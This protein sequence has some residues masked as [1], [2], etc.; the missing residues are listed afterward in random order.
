[1]PVLSRNFGKYRLVADLGHGG[2]ANVYLAAASGPAGVTKLLVVK[3]IKPEMA[4]D[5]AFVEMFLDEARLA[6]RVNHPNV[7]QTLEVGEEGGR[8]FLSMEFLDGQPLSRIQTRQGHER[9]TL[10][11]R[12]RVLADA[13]I[14]LHHAHEL[15]SYDGRPLGVVHR[16]ATPQ[17]IFVTY[18]GQVKVVDFGVAKAAT[19]SGQTST[20]VIKGKLSYMAPEQAR[21]E[22]IDRRADVFSVGVMFWE[23]VTGRRMWAGLSSEMGI[24]HRLAIGEVPRVPPDVAPEL[25]AIGD[26]ALAPEAA[27]RYPTAAAMAEDIE[28]YLERQRD[29]GSS[30]EIGARVGRMFATERAALHRVVNEQLAAIELA[31]TGANLA[32]PQIL[33]GETV[34]A[35]PPSFPDIVELSSLTAQPSASSLPPP[36]PAPAVP[37]PVVAG[38]G[39]NR[40]LVLLGVAVG[41]AS[42]FLLGAWRGWASRSATE[43][44]ASVTT[45]PSARVVSI[46]IAVHPPAARMFFDDEPLTGNPVTIMRPADGRTHLVRAEANEFLPRVRSLVVDKDY[47]LDFSLDRDPAAGSAVRPPVA[48]GAV[49]TAT[50][51]PVATTVAG[52][53]R[54]AGA[55]VV[56][57][58]N[59]AAAAPDAPV[60]KPAKGRRNV[61]ADNPYGP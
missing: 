35:L 48:G 25:R 42:I 51:S 5:P 33:D 4:S 52:P 55:T 59:N 14:G 18:D 16:D 30:R 45:A 36:P 58:A 32:L 13:L 43:P 3:E 2:M 39:T 7:V 57:G 21:G 29:R 1:M 10:S 37:P 24:L 9:L 19:S 11:E 50:A 61:D 22:P 6:A 60:K 54:P 47:A 40:P 44:A 26:R 38:P 46:Q 49:A 56:S 34:D 17:N 8:Y 23:A 15:R 20:G 12:L 41:V 27:G 53:A 28:R 31:A